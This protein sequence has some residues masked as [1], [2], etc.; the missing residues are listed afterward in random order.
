MVLLGFRVL[1]AFVLFGPILLMGV[2]QSPV[3]SEAIEPV[4]DVIQPQNGERDRITQLIKMF[5]TGEGFGEGGYG[6]ELSE[7]GRLG[8]K[9]PEI[10]SEL[11]PLLKSDQP[12]IRSSAIEVLGS[13]GSKSAILQLVPLLKDPA[14]FVRIHAAEVLGRMGES[15]QA[16]SALIPLL[17]HPKSNIR[18]EGN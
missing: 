17:K 18:R 13:I 2:A 15:S 16:I 9:N 12:Y 3:R 5:R 11:F 8:R 6:P 10:V 7:L 4:A 1:V 14:P